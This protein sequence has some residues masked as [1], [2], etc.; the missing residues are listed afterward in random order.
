MYVTCH[1]IHIVI[2]THDKIT[3][4]HISA[5]HYFSKNNPFNFYRRHTGPINVITII[6]IIYYNPQ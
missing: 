2:T 3:S 1:C 6:T 5:I 4:Q